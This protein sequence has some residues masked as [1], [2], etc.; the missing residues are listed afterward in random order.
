[1][2]KKKHSALY[3]HIEQLQGARPWGELLDAGT[4]TNSIRWV[5][6]LPT[7]S[8]TAVTGSTGEADLVRG[9]VNGAL[10]PDDR[11][12]TGNWADAQ[13]L[14]GRVFDTVLADYLLGA[15]EGFAPYFQS[16][17]FKRL[18]P[19]TRGRLYMTG[20]E[21]YVPTAR[22]ETKAARLVWEIG[23][24]RDACGL[25]AGNMPYRE[26]PSGWVIDHLKRA[27][28]AVQNIKHFDVGY[29]N[30]FVNAQIDISARGLEALADRDL[31][32]ALKGRG[33]ALRAEALEVIREE[34]A[35][36]AC[37]NYVI[38]AEPV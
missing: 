6:A 33:E 15:M 5:Q 26:Y 27:G 38:T 31:A 32:K 35:L 29:K 37:R 21:P 14:K 30:L 24:Y 12:I 13:L 23:R 3:R 19:L 10:R 36:R 16:Y 25:M 20:L 1:V 11:I 9:A 34:G 8:W 18:R 17:L 28:F 4:G 22:P 2:K 7:E